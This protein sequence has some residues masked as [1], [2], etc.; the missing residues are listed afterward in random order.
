MNSHHK[1]H[2][3]AIVCEAHAVI[4]NMNRFIQ[5][6]LFCIESISCHLQKRTNTTA[7]RIYVATGIRLLCAFPFY[8]FDMSFIIN[9]KKYQ[10]REKKRSIE[11][12]REMWVAGYTNLQ[13]LYERF[14]GK[15]SVAFTHAQPIDRIYCELE[16]YISLSSNALSPCRC[17]TYYSHIYFTIANANE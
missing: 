11:K 2:V 12:E 1:K 14:D 4:L 7:Y 9:K 16:Q 8:C 6:S 10:E 13:Q 5:I 15:R 3:I 17:Q